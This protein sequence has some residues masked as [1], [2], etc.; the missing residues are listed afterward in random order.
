M[1]FR[2]TLKIFFLFF[3]ALTPMI[4]S[5]QQPAA[6]TVHGMVT[7]PDDAVIPGA[8][9]TLTPASGKGKGLVAQSQSDGTFTL[10]G[11]PAGTYSMT[12]TMQGFA[13]F[14]KQDVR[15]AAGQSLDART[16][17]WRSRSRRRR[18]R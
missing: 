7:D 6:A 14:V 10:R 18:F 3:I 11:V 16:R 12:V 13:T 1:S 2:S 15:V 8:T 9:V 4:V 17:R 5:A